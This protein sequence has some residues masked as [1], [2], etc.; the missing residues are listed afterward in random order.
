LH[1]QDRL[2]GISFSQ[3]DVDDVHGRNFAPPADFLPFTWPIFSPGRFHIDAAKAWAAPGVRK[4]LGEEAAGANEVG[5]RILGNLLK[6]LR[7]CL[8]AAPTAMAGYF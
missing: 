2:W 4:W 5:C 1:S 3:T 6:N 7:A 8:N